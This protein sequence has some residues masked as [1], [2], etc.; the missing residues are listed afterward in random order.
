M[1]F[2]VGICSDLGWTR[3]LIS[4]WALE[5]LNMYSKDNIYIDMQAGINFEVLR[6][7]ANSTISVVRMAFYPLDCC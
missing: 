6:K 4:G 2:A 1:K 3:N 5:S 7:G